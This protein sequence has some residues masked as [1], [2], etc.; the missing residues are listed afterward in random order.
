MKIRVVVVINVLLA[1]NLVVADRVLSAGQIDAILETLTQTSA[2][3]W[4]PAGT[5]QAKHLEYYEMEK[6]VYESNETMYFDGSRFYWEIALNSVGDEEEKASGNSPADANILDMNG[7]RVFCWDGSTYTRYYKSSDSAVVESRETQAP[8][9]TYG[10]FSA[11]VVPW[12]SGIYTLQ[13]LS[14]C[15]CTASEVEVNGQRQIRLQIMNENSSLALQMN[16]V[17]DPDKNYAVI[18]YLLQDPQTSGI[19]QKYGQYIQINDRWV[20]TVITIE[21]FLK[22]PQGKRVMS[23]EDW[24][25]ESV[26]PEIPAT[27]DF[28][29]K[30]KNGTLVEFQPSQKSGSLMYYANDQ[31]DISALLGEKIAIAAQSEPARKNCA[32]A[33]A[34]FITKRF[35]RSLSTAQMGVLVS[36]QNGMTSLSLLKEKLE[37]SGLYCT[38]V[39]TNLEALREINNS[40][41]ILHLP[42]SSH[43]VILDHIDDKDVWTIDLTSRKVYWKTPIQQF[44]QGWKYG[45]A[46]IV[47]DAPQNLS[48]DTIVP[49]SPIIQQQIMGGDPAGYSCT[50]LLQSDDRQL[51]SDPVGILCGGR[52][53]RFWERY[54]CQENPKGG[55]CTGQGLPGHDYTHCIADFSNPGSCTITGA[56]YRRYI[57][58]CQ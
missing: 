44:L 37:E 20:P 6:T 11:G 26:K 51:C 19:E 56:W 36:Q 27:M 34:S 45:T 42:A 9:G 40:M 2:Q 4:L 21:R 18:S 58:A 55:T 24:R 12:G 25:F 10:P 35:S 17:L 31:S 16:F 54:G 22:T 52:Y 14:Q 33:A 30:L 57:R 49:L 39:E 48:T 53:Y 1:C 47:S 38:A 5:I 8:F 23:Y 7:R 13:K 3:T 28:S 29:V 41:I 32:T 43:Y 50:E 15:T 46:L